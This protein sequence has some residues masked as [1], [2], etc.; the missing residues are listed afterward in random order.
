MKK[1]T[2]KPFQHIDCEFWKSEDQLTFKQEVKYYLLEM[3]VIE[4]LIY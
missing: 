2:F 1:L 3:T 4:I